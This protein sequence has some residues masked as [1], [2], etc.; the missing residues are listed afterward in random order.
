M[1]ISLSPQT[2]KLLEEQMRKG[3]FA[4]PDEA[5]QTALRALDGS[6]GEDYADLDSETRDAIEQAEAEYDRGEGR[7]WEEVR[8]ELLARFVKR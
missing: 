2:Q 1:N 7:P 6:T 4:T 5:M 8:E 3:R